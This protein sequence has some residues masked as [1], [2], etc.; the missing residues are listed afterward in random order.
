MRRSFP[1]LFV[2]ALGVA[3]SGGSGGAKGSATDT[4]V[5]TSTTPDAP[6][7]PPTAPPAPAATPGPAA[8][9]APAKLAACATYEANESVRALGGSSDDLWAVGLPGTIL[10]FDGASWTTTCLSEPVSL[11]AVWRAGP[12]DAWATGGQA[13]YRFDGASWAR[14]SLAATVNGTFGSVWGSSANDV[15]IIAEDVAVHWNGQAFTTTTLADMRSLG[16]PFGAFREVWG[17]AANDVWLA[18]DRG[19]LHWDGTTWWGSLAA[20]EDE[21]LSSVWADGSRAWTAGVSLD[22]GGAAWRW[23]GA[24]RAEAWPEGIPQLA[25]VRG[26]STGEVFFQTTSDL[27]VRKDGATRRLGPPST[28]AGAPLVISANDVYLPDARGVAR[29]DGAGWTRSLDVPR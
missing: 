14:A 6:S 28:P 9:P 27:L 3:C 24:W 23:E 26:A 7:T 8:T 16:F 4:V 1:A 25:S 5:P 15:W 22:G 20:P 10:H 12:R 18:A 21:L 11:A 2:L 19:T 13:I 29:W 17:S